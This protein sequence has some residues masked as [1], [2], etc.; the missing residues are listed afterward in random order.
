MEKVVRIINDENSI[1]YDQLLDYL[2]DD[3]NK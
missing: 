1:G 3:R 2:C